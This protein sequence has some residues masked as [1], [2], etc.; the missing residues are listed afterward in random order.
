MLATKRLKSTP[1]S[2]DNVI[3]PNTSNTPDE[4]SKVPVNPEKSK[5]AQQGKVPPPASC[6]ST[7]PPPELASK[8]T[9]LVVVGALAPEDPP[10]VVLQFA[11]EV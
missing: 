7:V 1:A 11:V 5:E 10:D 3:S 6:T 9:P 8:Y 4:L 2:A